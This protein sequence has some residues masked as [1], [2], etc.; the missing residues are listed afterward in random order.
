MLKIRSRL[1]PLF[2]VFFER[3]GVLFISARLRPPGDPINKPEG[4][5][6]DTKVFVGFGLQAEDAETGIVE[7]HRKMCS[8]VA[9]RKGYWRNRQASPVNR[10]MPGKRVLPTVGANSRRLR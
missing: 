6:A 10:T 5:I 7:P 1:N 2:P 9:L 4:L 8:F 3:P